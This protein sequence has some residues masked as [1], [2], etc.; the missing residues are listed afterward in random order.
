MVS[1]QKAL[2]SH[3]VHHGKKAGTPSPGTAQL[4]Y[5][6]FE[7]V[8]AGTIGS[9]MVHV[10]AWSGGAGGSTKNPT[11]DS[12]NNPYRYALKERD[13]KKHHVHGGPIPPG[14]Y[15]ILPPAKHDKLGLSAKL[16]PSRTLPNHRGGFYIHGQGPHGS[17]GCIVPE[18][19]E[20]PDLMAKLKASQGGTLFVLEGMD[21]SFA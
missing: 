16:E 18:K 13:S 12:A 1:K 21:G 19:A 6:I 2:H 4:T 15:Q 7:G 9:D 17:D 14:K 5:Y 8:L 3:L 11:D 20:F 10:I